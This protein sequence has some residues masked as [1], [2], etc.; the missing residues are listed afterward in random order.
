[1]FKFNFNNLENGQDES[2]TASKCE[3]QNTIEYH[4][5]APKENENAA[6]IKI[7]YGIFTYEELNTSLKKSFA[8]N[9]IFFKN[10]LLCDNSDDKIT[11]CLDYVD[12]YRLEIDENDSLSKINK[13]HDLVAGQYEGGL[14]VFN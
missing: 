10:F 7:E 12:A 14:K 9:E 5:Y 11:S 8:K 6:E 13:T 2:G 4:N 3:K 1:M